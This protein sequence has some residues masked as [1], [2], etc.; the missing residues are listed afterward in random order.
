MR[1]RNWWIE[2][3]IDGRETKMAGGPTRKDGGF[4]LSIRQRANGESVEAIKVEGT[5][6]PEGTLIL[7]ARSEAGSQIQSIEVRSKR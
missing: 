2:G 1:M 3:R 7:V 5:V 4:S 6:T